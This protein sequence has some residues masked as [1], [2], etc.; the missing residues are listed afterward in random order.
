[1]FTAILGQLT[2]IGN[3]LV[4]EQQ[5]PA[6]RQWVADYLR[7]VIAE[8]GWTPAPDESDERKQLRAGVVNVL[9]YIA[10]DEET[11]R[12]ARELTELALKDPSAVDPTLAETVVPLA[13]IHGD[14][15]LLGKMKAAIA[16]AKSPGQYYRY[17]Y[18]LIAF[19]DPA[20]RK[21]AFAA[22]LSADMRSQDLPHFVGSM[23]EKPIR[24]ARSVGL[25]QDQLER[26][27]E[28]IHA[29]GRRLARGF[30]RQPVRRQTAP[31]RAALLR[32]APGAGVRAL[33]GH[34][35]REDRHVCGDAHPADAQ[36]RGMVE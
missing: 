24:R 33:A 32:R 17:L 35:P 20:L 6:Y 34:G 19:E 27:A 8:L 22:A 28:E 29:V 21:E 4:T 11:L 1:M 23:F 7:P 13:A 36:L 30:H 12:K 18:A 2:V 26:A 3:D 14:A 9:G 5:A 31:G 25:R 16:E 15:A 10:R